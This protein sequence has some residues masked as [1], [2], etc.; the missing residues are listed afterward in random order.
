MAQA[1]RFNTPRFVS[2]FVNGIHVVLDKATYRHVATPHL[3][4]LADQAAADFN[5]GRRRLGG[6]RRPSTFHPR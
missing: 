4:K 6:D 3:K 5:A 2:R 1:V